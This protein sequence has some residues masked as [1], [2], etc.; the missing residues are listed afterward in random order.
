MRPNISPTFDPH[1]ARYWDPRDLE[2]E[3]ERVFGICHGCRMCVGYCPSFP[4]LFKRVDGYVTLDKGSVDAFNAE[5]YKAVNDLCFQCKLCYIKCPYTPD[6]QHA[7]SVDFPRLMLRH[8]AQRAARDGIS[9]QDQVLGEPQLVGR[10]GGGFHHAL[11]ALVAPQANFVA[12]SRLLRK[13]QQKATGISA[14]FNVPPFASQWLR[15]WFDKHSERPEAGTH[16]EVALFSTC[17]TDYNMPSTGIAAIQVL[18]HNG[19]RVHF[20]KEQTC[21]GMP[22]M[23]GGDTQAAISKAKQNV[24]TLYAFVQRGI[25]IVVPGPTCGYVLKK[26]YP[27]LVGTDEARAVA[28]NTFDLMEFLRLRLKNDTLRR[29]FTTPLGKVAYHAACHL[30]AQKIGAPGRI[31]LSKVQDTDVE[32]IEECSAVD[33]TWGMKAQYY[34]L[35]RRYAR[36]MINALGT[37]SDG[38]KYDAVVSDCPLSGQRIAAELGTEAWHPIELLNK[39]YGLPEVKA[40]SQ[41][42]KIRPESSS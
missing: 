5:D 20:P 3:L 24:A 34:E 27:E 1:D 18:E 2:T 9:T 10:A 14:E 33:G 8:K 21:C 26:E 22:N 36:K 17:T 6:D 30:R 37:H 16:G 28:K 25:P 15:T 13:V 19:L 4:E 29:D 12:S 31:V 32:L 7:F 39:A 38:V 35:G 41:V 23:D 42:P 11:T 40:A